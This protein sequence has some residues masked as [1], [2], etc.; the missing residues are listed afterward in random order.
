MSN[1]SAP[2]IMAILSKSE[3]SLTSISFSLSTLG[4]GNNSSWAELLG[5]IGNEFPNLTYFYLLNLS[6][7]LL[8]RSYVAFPGL[9]KDSVIGQPYRNGLRLFERRPLGGYR[10]PGVEYGGPNASH[11]L[12]IV[13]GCVITRFP[14]LLGT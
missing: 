9:D 8:P 2:T 11:V 13:A 1:L 12:R 14:P 3:Q 10:I 6:E 5:R 7:G 4:N